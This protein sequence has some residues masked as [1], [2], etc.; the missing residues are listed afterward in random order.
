MTD[1]I[2]TLKPKTVLFKKYEIIKKIDE[3]SFGKIYLSKNIKTK[4]KYAIKVE[5]RKP[6]NSSLER[7]AYILLQIFM[8]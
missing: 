4:E 6:N 8:F 2:V 1:K 3:G 7:E 5:P